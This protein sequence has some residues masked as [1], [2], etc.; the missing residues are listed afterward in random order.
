MSHDAGKRAEEL[1]HKLRKLKGYC[2]MTPEEAD[3]AYDAAPA[4]PI[5]DDEIDSM[6][7]L[8]TSGRKP[9]WEP[10]PDLG[11]TDDIDT[12]GVEE[13]SLQLHSNK[14]EEGDDTS[15]EDRLREEMLS[16]D[17]TEDE[18]GLGDGEEPSVGGR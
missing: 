7:D 6:I 5:S 8:V 12:S 3:A 4:D 2:P 13:D 10:K 16:D 9:T 15:E 18:D 17:E 1:F 11:W 14:G